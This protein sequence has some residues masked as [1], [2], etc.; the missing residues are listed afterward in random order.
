MDDSPS[1][2]LT[3][4]S[5]PTAPWYAR[6]PDDFD[7][8]DRRIGLAVRFIGGRYNGFEG[9]ISWAGDTCCAVVVEYEGKRIEE[10][11]G[12]DFLLPLSAWRAAKSATELQLKGH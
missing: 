1:N 11:E 5:A 6:H 9:T 12:F 10:V 2:A 4:Q 7:K 3:P 8:Q